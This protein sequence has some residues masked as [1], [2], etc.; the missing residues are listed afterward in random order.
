MKVNVTCMDCEITVEEVDGKCI[1]TAEQN[2]EVVEEFT[3][4]CGSEESEE[5]EGVE[6][7]EDVD[8]KDIDVEEMEDEDEDEVVEE[9]VKSFLNFIKK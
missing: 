7:M 8:L 4:D 5:V 2:G 9:N 1:V 3:V 6:D